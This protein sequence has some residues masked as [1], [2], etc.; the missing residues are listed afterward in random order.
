MIVWMI[1]SRLIGLVDSAEVAPQ[2][3]KP[4]VVQDGVARTLI[5]LQEADGLVDARSPL[6]G[7]LLVAGLRGA[8]A[9][10]LQQLD[11]VQKKRARAIVKNMMAAGFKQDSVCAVC[12]ALFLAESQEH[13]AW[14]ASPHID[15]QSN[16]HCGLLELWT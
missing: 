11:G 2:R 4:R 13:P 7:Q 3:L 14:K 8:R 15:S 12:R 6:A 10:L 9:R 1:A 16:R 5:A